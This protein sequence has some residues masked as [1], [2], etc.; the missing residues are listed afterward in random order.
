[1]VIEIEFLIERLLKRKSSDY[2]FIRA[3]AE[4]TTVV[5]DGYANCYGE[6]CR[7]HRWMLAKIAREGTCA[8]MTDTALLP[9]K[10]KHDREFVLDVRVNGV[11]RPINLEWHQFKK[12]P[13]EALGLQVG[14]YHRLVAAWAI[15][16]KN[17]PCV[18]AA[19]NEQWMSP[20]PI[21]VIEKVSNAESAN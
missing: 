20:L 9:A 1:M 6:G 8:G 19:V 17:I 4:F 2:E 12:N 14:G 21:W 18:I 3:F 13:W 5:L 15:G 7:Y 11:L 10:L 16:M